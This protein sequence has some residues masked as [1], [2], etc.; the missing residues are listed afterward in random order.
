MR[1][2]PEEF[3]PARLHGATR[4]GGRGARGLG[5]RSQNYSPTD[6]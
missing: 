1:Q 4:G 2:L 6:T 3:A 5:E